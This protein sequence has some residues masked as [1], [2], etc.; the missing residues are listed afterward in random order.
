LTNSSVYAGSATYA[1]TF[2][3]FVYHFSYDDE[4]PHSLSL[5]QPTAGQRSSKLTLVAAIRDGGERKITGKSI[6][7]A[8]EKSQLISH[9]WSKAATPIACRV[10]LW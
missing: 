3:Q 1:G 8:F 2:R 4:I 9:N 5:R 6:S 7:G 10:T